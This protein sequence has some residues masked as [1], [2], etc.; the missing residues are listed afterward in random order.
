MDLHLGRERRRIRKRRGLTLDQVSLFCGV[1]RGQCRNVA[2][3]DK[4][5]REH[6]LN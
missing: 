3:W 2:G 6:K 1:N 5:R 4:K